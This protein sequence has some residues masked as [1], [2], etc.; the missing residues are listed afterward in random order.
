MTDTKPDAERVFTLA[1]VELTGAADRDALIAALNLKPADPKADRFPL[2]PSLWPTKAHPVREGWFRW[3]WAVVEQ[4]DPDAVLATG[5]RPT[6]AWARRK[7]CRVQA[8]IRDERA[9]ARKAE[10]EK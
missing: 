1:D 2:E 6:K 4:D 8:Q 9:A 3:R 5:C 7:S 10:A